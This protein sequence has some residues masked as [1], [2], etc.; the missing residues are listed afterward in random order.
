MEFQTHKSIQTERL[1]LRPITISDANDMFEYTSLDDSNKYLSW[2]AHTDIEQTINFIKEVELKYQTSKTEYSW[3]IELV[4]EKKL[5]G[6]VKLF[7]ISHNNKRAEVSYIL[8]PKF[9]GKGYVNEAI[10]AVIDLAFSKLAF[11]RIQARCSNDNVASEKV[12][13]KS[14]MNFEGLL[15][16]YWILKGEYKDVVLY[17][18]TK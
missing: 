8:N 3:G 4:T 2:N 10:N 16:K 14:G 9:Q 18:I 1:L 13:Q 12:M 11:T 17:A 7:E 5:I 6:V 15:K